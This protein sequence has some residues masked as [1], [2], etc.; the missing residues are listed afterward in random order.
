MTEIQ[1]EEAKPTAIIIDDMASMRGIARIMLNAVGCDVVG[2]AENGALGLTLYQ[3]Q[4]PDLVLLDIE[5]PV[6]DGVSTLK[7]ILA[8]DKNAY[9]VMMTT[10]SNQA[11]V[12]ACI[13]AGAK[14]YIVKDEDP[15][16]VKYRLNDVVTAMI[17]DTR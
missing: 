9:I 17:A 5:M 1:S 14:D 16:T 3:D 8:R 7:S 13:V 4:K 2:E 15:V 10:V 6:K 12:E 11:V